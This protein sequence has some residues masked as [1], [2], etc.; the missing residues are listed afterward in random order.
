[1][2]AALRAVHE[3]GPAMTEA[4]LR[5]AL[6]AL[7]R[8]LTGVGA[9]FMIIGGIA[10][11]ARGVPRHTDDVDVTVWAPGLD[12][13]ALHRHL[14]S[15]DIVFRIEDGLAFAQQNQIVL[16]VHAPSKIEIDLSLAWLP[17]EEAALQ[18]APNERLRGIVVPV[19][20]AE[21]LVIYKAL[22]WRDR[23]RSDITRLLALHRD[24]IDVERVLSVVAPLAEAMELPER[25]RELARLLRLNE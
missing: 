12:L 20:C 3:R 10:V 8:A 9:P 4:G 17:F 19:A 16:L 11:V 22:A 25:T 1:M 21:D 6:A 23:D 15:Q 2:G 18:R 24:D 5:R 14:A 7:K 13:D